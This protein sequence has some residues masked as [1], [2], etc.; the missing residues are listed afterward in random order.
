[1]SKKPFHLLR[2]PEKY[3]VKLRDFKA[4][5]IGFI[6]IKGAACGVHYHN[7]TYGMEYK[8]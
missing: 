3:I 5:S 6:L 8:K 4:A 1:M 7:V 2:W